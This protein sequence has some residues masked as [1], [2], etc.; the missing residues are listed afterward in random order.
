[1]KQATQLL[2]IAVLLAGATALRAEFLSVVEV[3][4]LRGNA[5]YRVCSDAEKK[6]LEAEVRGEAKVYAKALEETKADWKTL[7][8]DSPF[9]SS[10]IKQR[11][12]RVLTTTPNR[13]EAD[14]YASKKESREEDALADDKRD[15]ERVLTMKP[16][17]SRHGR[18][19]AAQVA[20]LQQEVKKD[21]ER[22]A[23]ADKAEAML[24]KKLTA[25]CGHEVPFFGEA[26]P[27]P[28]PAAKK[29]K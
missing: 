12:L 7:Q 27:E 6:A 26:P 3:T 20:R 25:A 23:S 1:M 21:R 24:R 4:D 22:D 2:S 8:K 28:K 29:K 17:R 15:Q 9:P 13:E 16:T 11:E 14:A 5:E 18:S 10:R 19:N